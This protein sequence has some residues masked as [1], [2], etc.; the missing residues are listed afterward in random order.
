MNAPWV[1][2]KMMAAPL[3]K[4]QD[5]LNDVIIMKGTAG[6]ARLLNLLI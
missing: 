3:S 2:M 1:D 6:R 5:G 4:L